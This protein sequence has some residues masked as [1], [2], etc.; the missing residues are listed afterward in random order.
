MLHMAGGGRIM[1][2]Q[3]PFVSDA[4]VEHVVTHL[5]AQGRPDY[6]GT[7]TEDENEIEDDADEGYCSL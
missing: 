7:V 5:K 1:R 2:V 6:L 4:E 3:G